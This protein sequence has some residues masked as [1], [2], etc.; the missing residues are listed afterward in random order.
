MDTQHCAFSNAYYQCWA[1]RLLLVRFSI[2]IPACPC[3]ELRVS[4]VMSALHSRTW[5]C[6]ST[7]CTKAPSRGLE[8]DVVT[9]QYIQNDRLQDTSRGAYSGRDAYELLQRETSVLCS[10]KV[11]G[12]YI[13]LNKT[14]SKIWQ[15]WS[16]FPVSIFRETKGIEAS[17][18]TNI[19]FFF[20]HSVQWWLILN[21]GIARMGQALLWNQAGR[22]LSCV[23]P[24]WFLLVYAASGVGFTTGFIEIDDELWDNF[25]SLAQKQLV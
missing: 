6:G 1:Q 18:L 12:M 21:F 15:S 7:A 20:F 3:S 5:C 10:E 16:L 9:G 19:F 4:K 24:G 13:F 11:H 14:A 17:T 2:L 8:I 25:C 23:K 22:Q